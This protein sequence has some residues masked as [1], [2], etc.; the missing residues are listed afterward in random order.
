MVETYGLRP[1]S[2]GAGRWR[3]GTGLEMR[4][5]IRRAGSAVLG[6][7][8]ERFVFRPWGVA[9]GGPGATCRVILN[10]GLPGERDL[11]KLDMYVAEA[12]DRVTILTAG[13]GGFG[14]PFQR[15]PQ[16]V[17][18][19][20]IAGFVSREAAARDYGV[21]LSGNTVDLAATKAL[22]AAGPVRPAFDFGP[23]REAWENVFDDATLSSLA[24]RLLRLPA[25]I[26]AE[27]RRRIFEAALPELGR[28]AELGL[29]AIMDDPK[30]IR[31]RLDAAIAQ[32]V[33]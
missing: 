18:R 10:H 16:T 1:D 2:G 20:V 5:L 9:G 23:E 28:V 14:D 3:G 12:G 11:G 19:D 26:R 8:L 33:P 21:V 30:A 24:E 13:G 15:D 7:G 31:K 27:T 29:P 6:R 22:R 25:T 17:L 4:M 32:H